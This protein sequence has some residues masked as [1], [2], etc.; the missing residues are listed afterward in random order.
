MPHPRTQEQ[1]K[2]CAS[3]GT[4][5]KRKRINGRLEDMGAFSRRKFC[6]RTCYSAGKVTPTPSLATLRSRAHREVPLR[7]SCETCG[8]RTQLNRHHV[9]EN[10]ADNRPENVQTL[11]APCHTRWHWMNGKRA[12]YSAPLDGIDEQP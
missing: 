9:N 12:T 3:C 10:P 4:P 1:P 2:P 7:D 11:C 5:M 6:G 8:S